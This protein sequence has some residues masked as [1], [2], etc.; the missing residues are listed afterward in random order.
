MNAD[1]SMNAPKETLKTFLKEEIENVRK[2]LDVL[3][4]S[5]KADDYDTLDAELK[6]RSETLDSLTDA[7]QTQLFILRREIGALRENMETLAVKQSWWSSLPVYARI[8]VV[9]VPVVIYLIVLSLIQLLNKGQIYDYQ[10]TQTAIASQTMLA[11][12]ATSNI[13]ATLSAPV[14]TPAPTSTLAP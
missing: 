9:T 14:G 7:D 8:L 5:L 11:T 4:G 3:K 10:A 1:N 2:R 12:Q 6:E 13:E